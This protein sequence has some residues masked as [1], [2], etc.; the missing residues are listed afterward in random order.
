M[1]GWDDKMDARLR[2][3]PMAM[4]TVTFDSV[5]R[6]RK[7]VETSLDAADTSVRATL[8]GGV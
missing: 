6:E 5:S 4:S 8:V 1:F 7:S 2:T 3:A